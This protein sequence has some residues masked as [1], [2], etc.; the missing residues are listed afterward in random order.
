MLP[1]FPPTQD[2]K[3]EAIKDCTR[4]I[5][6]DETYTKAVL[7]RANLHQDTDQLDEALKDFQ[8]VLELQ[9]SNREAQEA[10]RVRQGKEGE[11][12]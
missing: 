4:A 6:L 11:W 3:K 2:Q 10:V 12:E 1:S 8:R 9:P 7:R 5:E